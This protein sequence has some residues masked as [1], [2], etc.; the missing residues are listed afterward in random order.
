MLERK[1]EWAQNLSDELKKWVPEHGYTA[2]TQLA[3]ELNIPRRPWRDIFGGYG[4]AISGRKDKFDGRI[5]YA[6]VHLWTGLEMSDPRTI[7]DRLIR[8][9]GKLVPGKRSFSEAEYQKWLKSPDG[10]GLL[11]KKDARFKREVVMESE[12]TPQPARPVESFSQQAQPSETLGSLVGSFIDGLINRGADQIAR[13]LSE[14]QEDVLL[15]KF[16]LLEGR[17]AALEGIITRLA[18]QPQAD[19]IH[20]RPPRRGRASNDI[21]QIASHLKNLLDEYRQ[22]TSIDRDKLMERYGKELMD[23]DMLVHPLTRRPNQREE[24]IRLTEEIKV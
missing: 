23:L 24:M 20:S 14:R 8:L 7:P 13:A 1:P 9:K 22:G 2:S 3:D 15:P 18:T 5:F 12:T 19:Q 10:Q 17:V 21:G 11:A 4:I 6:R 16:S